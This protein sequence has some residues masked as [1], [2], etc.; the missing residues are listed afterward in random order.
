MELICPHCQLQGKAPESILGK[1]IKCPGCSEYFFTSH[2]IK[3]SPPQSVSNQPQPVETP[4]SVTPVQETPDS[5][6]PEDAQPQ[7]NQLP[8]GL[9]VCSQCGFTF[10]DKFASEQDTAVLCS[11]CSG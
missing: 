10:S 2:N 4:A 9:L 8:E 7:A 5:I 6:P 11:L 1:T 3:V